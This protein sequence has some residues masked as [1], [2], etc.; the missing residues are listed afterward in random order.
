[1][2][3]GRSPKFINF[4]EPS[5]IIVTQ[6]PDYAAKLAIF[7]LTCKFQAKIFPNFLGFSLKFPE[8]YILLINTLLLL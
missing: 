4:D 7:K 8:F 3:W 6:F 5:P 2:V 1:M